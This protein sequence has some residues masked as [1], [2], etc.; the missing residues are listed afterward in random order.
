MKRSLTIFASAAISTGVIVTTLSGVTAVAAGAAQNAPIQTVIEQTRIDINHVGRGWYSH[1]A[2]R[3]EAVLTPQLEVM[4]ITSTAIG[5]KGKPKVAV[6]HLVIINGNSYTK[7]SGAS[8]YTEDPLTSAALATAADQVN[9]YFIE[10]KFNAIGGVKLVG[11]RHY[12]TVGAGTQVRAFL[13][14]AFG[15]TGAALTGYEIGETT[16]D[17]WVNAS[18]QPINITVTGQSPI[19]PMTASETFTSY[20]QPVTIYPPSVVPST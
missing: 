13:T 9:P 6:A 15:L 10:A 1:S 20:N 18:G 5:D 7:P 16:I 4:A 8:G 11:T 19:D 12:Q 2:V 17:L 3:T 14:A